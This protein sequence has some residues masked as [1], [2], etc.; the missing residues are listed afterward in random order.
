MSGPGRRDDRDRAR[1]A[2]ARRAER[3]HAR[4]GRDERRRRHPRRRRAAAHDR[5]RDRVGP[6]GGGAADRHQVDRR[7]RRLDRVGR[8]RRLPARRARRAPGP[9]PGP[10]CYGRGGTRGDRHRREPAARPPQPRVLPRRADATRPVGDRPSA[11]EALGEP[12]GLAPLEL[13]ASIVE[14]ANENMASAIKMV[15]LERGH[16][17]RRFSLLAFGGAG[18]LHAAAVARVLGIPKVIVPAAPRRLLGARPAARRHPRRQGLDAGVPL[19]RTST[20]RSSNRQFERITE[21]ALA[22]LRQEGFAGEPE[23]QRAINMRY[24]G[25]NYEHEVEIDAG[26]LDEAALER[27]FRRFDELHAERYGYAIERRGDRAR[28]LQGDRDRQARAARPLARRTAR[29]RSTRSERPVYVRGHGFARRGRRAPLLA[30]AGR[31]D[32]RARP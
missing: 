8:R 22:E 12:I 6:A 16:D 23:I 32:R 14:I 20:R 1:R 24:F 30:R 19:E 10:I 9:H 13:A 26:E 21:R 3:A 18:P 17:P 27:A 29:R 4:H 2:R 11:M 15:S 7:R 5:V 28:Q 25:Q 31:G